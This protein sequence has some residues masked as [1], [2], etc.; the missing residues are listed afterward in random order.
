MREPIWSSSIA[1]LAAVG[2]IVGGLL[3]GWEPTG[4]DPDRV[5]RPIKTELSR[6]LQEGQ[7]PFWSDRFGL[8]VPLVAESQVGAF[9]PLN[10][11][12]YRALDVSV[13]YRL[14][15]WLHYLA[16]AGATYAYARRLKL[17]PW[18]SAVAAVAFTFCGF[19]TIHSSH[20]PFY[21]AL[22]FLLLA[23]YFTEAYVADAR[24]TWLALLAL[25]WGAQL[26]VGH[27]QIQM[28]TAALVLGTGLWR[29]V[30]DHVQRRMLGLAAALVGGAGIA[31]VQLVL[32]WDQAKL[33]G[34]MNRS[35]QDLRFFSYPPGHW[36]E[37]LV[38]PF[39]HS[40]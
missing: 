2:L 17:T 20:E 6:S 38:A 34:S 39:E 25:T 15:M 28:W 33:V 24:S 36:P 21:S 9:Y 3:V 37:V 16:L 4:G 26:T 23:L 40:T 29:C 13:A 7:L 12:L 1:A 19:Q 31:A 30:G 10:W 18:G 14:S 8:G 5:Y 35:L 27:F 11:V 22:P 32:S